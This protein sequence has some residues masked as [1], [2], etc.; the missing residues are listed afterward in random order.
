MQCKKCI[1]LFPNDDMMKHFFPATRSLPILGDD[2]EWFVPSIYGDDWG[3]VQMT[4]F[5]PHYHLSEDTTWCLVPRIVGP[6]ASPPAQGSEEGLGS[7]V[8]AG[9][10]PG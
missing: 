6:V 1:P 10:G 7:R 4:L 2:W 5:G 3:M 8:G 9:Q